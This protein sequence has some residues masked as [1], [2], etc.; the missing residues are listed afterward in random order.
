MYACIDNDNDGSISYKE[1][2][3]VVWGNKKVDLH[4]YIAKRRHDLGLDTGID[5]KVQKQ[6]AKE[7]INPLVDDEYRS[8]GSVSGLSALMKR[9]ED[10]KPVNKF[11]DITE[12]SRNFQ[13]IKSIF[14]DKF[15]TFE[16]LLQVM[17]QDSKTTMQARVTLK[18]LEKAVI[19]C[20]GRSKFSTFQIKSVFLIHAENQKAGVEQA[21]IPIREFKELFYPSQ[22]WTTD[23]HQGSSTKEF[24]DRQK[25]LRE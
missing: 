13:E 19:F 9:S 11:V 10:E 4:A 15:F 25:S 22:L 12:P 23:Y 24:V 5:P 7:S 2:C 6:L 21:F 20:C 16:E 14:K 18:E 1:F 8:V 17:F 3:D